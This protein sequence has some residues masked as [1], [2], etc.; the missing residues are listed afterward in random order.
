[1]YGLEALSD[2][3]SCADIERGMASW[4][5]QQACTVQTLKS[6][7]MNRLEAPKRAAFA[8]PRAA[9]RYR[10]PLKSARQVERQVAEPLAG[11]IGRVAQAR[12]AA[13]RRPA[14]HLPIHLVMGPARGHE[15]PQHA[16]GDRLVGH[17]CVHGTSEG[18]CAGRRSQEMD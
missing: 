4:T 11:A 15:M 9:G 5:Q 17:D 3:R 10:R 8:I 14:L 6:Q 13:E 1:M 12:H 2:A 18:N 7:R 16:G